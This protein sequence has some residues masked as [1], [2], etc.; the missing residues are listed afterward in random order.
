MKLYEV[1]QAIEELLTQLDPDPET[2][3][4]TATEDILLEL[5]SLQM[6]RNR[7]LEYLAK[8]VLNCRAE[9]ASIRAEEKR[10][11]ER[12]RG[13]ESR[14]ERLMQIL[15]RECAGQKTDCGVATVNY[16][17]TSRVE[18]S[19]DKAAIS[20]LKQHDHNDCYDFLEK[21]GVSVDKQNRNPSRLSRMPGV[22]RNG[23]RQYIVAENIGRKSWTDWLDF[24]EGVSDELPDVEPISAGMI[25]NPPPLAEELISGVLRCG[26]KML[27]SGSSKAGKSFLLIL[28]RR[29]L[30]REKRNGTLCHADDGGLFLHPHSGGGH[31]RSAAALIPIR[32]RRQ[33][34][35]SNGSSAVPTASR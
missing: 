12:R 32:R 16:R 29:Q 2:G 11:A 27:I 31:C 7:I 18:V 5:D 17:A 34:A 20:W 15:D 26:H 6:E 4:V 30:C 25:D 9:A 35:K 22:T 23:S 21:N 3:E 14:D 24:A 8:L 28:S 13:L 1:N 10:L 19:D 33:Q